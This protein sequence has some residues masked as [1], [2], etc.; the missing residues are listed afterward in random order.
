MYQITIVRTFCA[1]HAIRLG[2]GSWEPVHGHN[3]DVELTVAA[4]ELDG[5]ETVMDFHKLGRIVD[6][7]LERLHNRNL[8]EITPFASRGKQAGVNPTA[9][10]VAWWLGSQ[11]AKALPSNVRLEQVRVGEAPGCTAVFRPDPAGSG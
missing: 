3:W 8:N 9:E 7:P 1:A 4:D 2:D 11:V 5:I 6:G 10:R